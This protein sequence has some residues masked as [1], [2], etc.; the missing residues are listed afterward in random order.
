MEFLKKLF[1]TDIDVSFITT[2]ILSI[3]QF[4]CHFVVASSDGNLSYEE[5]QTIMKSANG[6]QLIIL[7]SA[8]YFYRK[9]KNFDK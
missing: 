8:I 1:K 2:S 4:I 5:I 9:S 3:I 6:F 7:F